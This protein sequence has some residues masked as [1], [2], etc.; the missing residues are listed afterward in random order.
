MQLFEKKKIK[1]I[2][3]DNIIAED[4][5]HKLNNDQ[6]ITLNQILKEL[7]E[8]YATNHD[9][10]RDV[11]FVLKNYS[12]HE[13]V[14]KLWDAFSKRGHNYDEYSVNKL[15]KDSELKNLD[16]L[17]IGSLIHWHKDITKNVS[18]I[19]YSKLF[20]YTKV[21]L[22]ENI[23]TILGKDNIHTFNSEKVFINN[24]KKQNVPFI[25]IDK[26]ISL[27]SSQTGSGKTF[28]LDKVTNYYK[29]KGYG[30]LSLVSRTSMAY[31]HS[32]L[33][34]IDNYINTPHNCH[35]MN[36]VYCVES[37]EKVP[38]DL[39]LKH[40]FMIK[41][42]EMGRYIKKIKSN[43]M[44]K[45]YKF[46]PKTAKY[47]LFLDEIHSLLTYFFNNQQKMSKNR[48]TFTRK[49]IDLINNADHVFGVDANTSSCIIK[50]LKRTCNKPI[51]L[52]INEHKPIFLQDVTFYKSPDKVIALMEDCI[53][54]NEYFFCASDRLSIFKKNV[55]L[56]LFKKF[57]EFKKKCLIYS[58]EDGNKLDFARASKL[59]K[60]KFVF[61]SPSVIYGID[62]NN[63]N[64]H[65]V[66]GYYFGGTIDALG[67]YQ[68][69]G[70]VRHPIA[71][72]IYIAEHVE[73]H[74]YNSI[75]EMIRETDNA[76]CDDENYLDF[77]E[78]ED[79]FIKAFRDFY[80]DYKYLSYRLENHR[81]H[82]PIF[83]KEK[84]FVNIKFDDEEVGD[85]KDIDKKNK[86]IM[87]DNTKEIVDKLLN[88]GVIDTTHKELIVDRLAI[89][90]YNLSNIDK[91]LDKDGAISNPNYNGGLVYVLDWFV[92][93]KKFNTLF[94][95]FLVDR[96]EDDFSK[97]LDNYKDLP[98]IKISNV[99]NKLL[100][101]D[102]LLIFLNQSRWFKLKPNRNMFDD[103]LNKIP[104]DFFLKIKIA[105]NVRKKNAPKTY[106][107][108]FK[109]LG[110]CYHSMFGHLTYSYA[111]MN[112]TK[113]YYLTN[114]NNDIY[115][116][117][118]FIVSK[119]INDIINL[120]TN[121]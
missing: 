100:L 7:P 107:E 33:F 77:I 20:I 71:I 72:H 34:G 116:K 35:S 49:L 78:K 121:Y 63:I 51:H 21:D 113:K 4:N 45:M 55:L 89:F 37:I 27:I 111:L 75:Y 52:Y 31:M 48:L 11:C 53:K 26:N 74:F 5:N 68:Q 115:E 120:F 94:N 24:N 8:E 41:S 102:Q 79:D 62:Y 117:L 64:T 30:I 104:D 59:W 9:K 118:F 67:S 1:K 83:L 61:C 50:F 91:M 96:H 76:L 22:L 44:Y 12:S 29:K 73:T 57:P 70:R 105:F 40:N 82:L 114:I 15:W 18:K 32:A 106:I 54:N 99:F 3:H 47:I 13:I 19:K 103:E 84:G 58:G 97:I 86:K 69:S 6:Y 85:K 16:G 38:L 42:Y 90:E 14:F 2:N 17:H 109:Q 98:E 28:Y 36:E 101:M 65:Y 43:K 108:W 81:F 60:N 95:I 56:P 46:K 110:D 112:K 23:E 10:W 92:D 93:S 66:F 25:D 88:G 119:N 87:S 80:Y 39:F